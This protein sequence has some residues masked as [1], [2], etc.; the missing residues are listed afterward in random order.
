M[1]LIEFLRL[2]LEDKVKGV[3]FSGI[4]GEGEYIE[5]WGN[6]QI[7]VHSRYKDGKL[8]GEY[9]WWHKNGELYMHS[10]YENGIEI[11]DYLK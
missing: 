7:Y 10:L 11:K 2:S 9:K 4:E 3:W 1:T 6:G 8:H 5:Y